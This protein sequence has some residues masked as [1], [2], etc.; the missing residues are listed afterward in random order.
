MCATDIGP[1]VFSDGRGDACSVDDSDVVSDVITR[2]WSSAQSREFH[3]LHASISNVILHLNV[4]KFQ[5][6]KFVVLVSDARVCGSIPSLP[7]LIAVFE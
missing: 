3:F 2:R 7:W 4:E 6:S 5:L 1:F